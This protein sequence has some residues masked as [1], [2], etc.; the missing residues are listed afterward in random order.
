[1]VAIVEN[2]ISLRL[3]TL[4]ESLGMRP[5]LICYRERNVKVV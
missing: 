1:M 2:A 3:E 5:I 4:G